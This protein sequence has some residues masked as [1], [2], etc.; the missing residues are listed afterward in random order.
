MNKHECKVLC[1]QHNIN[2]GK[3]INNKWKAKTIKEMKD[4]ISNIQG[5]SAASSYVRFLY[6]KDKFDFSKIKKPSKQLTNKY[7]NDNDIEDKKNKETLNRFQYYIKTYNEML[8][9]IADELNNNK[10]INQQYKK[11]Q[12]DLYRSYLNELKI[13]VSRYNQLAKNKL[14]VNNI[15]IKKISNKRFK[16]NYDYN[17][18][19]YS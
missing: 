9:E 6:G 10:T 12:I 3:T 7:A 1:K 15:E 19:I 16:I 11:Q 14:D 13:N 8:N 2:V 5:G 17:D 18:I 4:D